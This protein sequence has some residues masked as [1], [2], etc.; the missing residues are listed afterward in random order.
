MHRYVFIVAVSK[1]RLMLRV[2]KVNCQSQIQVPILLSKQAK[3]SPPKQEGFGLELT[4]EKILTPS[5]YPPH[6]P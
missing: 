1:V 4:I 5:N 6:Q 3:V 2:A